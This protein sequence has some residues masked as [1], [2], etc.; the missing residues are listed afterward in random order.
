[1][2]TTITKVIGRLKTA[3][4]GF[5]PGQNSVSQT[6]R[7]AV[8]ALA[9]VA[10]GVVT[11]G[12][13]AAPAYT[14]TEGGNAVTS[15]ATLNYAKSTLTVTSPLVKT[16]TIDNTG[17][18]PLSLTASDSG[19][20]ATEFVTAQSTTSIPASSTGTVT[21]TFTPTAV[22]AER[23]TTLTLRTNA[24]AATFT[25]VLKA[26][27]IQPQP[28][29]FST[30]VFNAKQT[31]SKVTVT[32]TRDKITAAQDVDFST[33]DGP[34]SVDGIFTSSVAGTDYTTKTATVHF[35]V[36][37]KSKTVEI[38]LTVLTGSVPNR[39]FTVTIAPQAGAAD[40]TSTPTPTNTATVRVLAT[41]TVKPTLTVD[42]PTDKA[43]VNTDDLDD[44]Q[45]T[46]SGS[47]SDEKG[48]AS[49]K[50]SINGGTA[51]AVDVEEGDFSHKVSPSLGS[52]KV[53]VTALDYKGNSTVVTRTFTITGGN[54]LAVTRALSTALPAKGFNVVGTVALT[55]TSKVD[56][57]A[58]TP[59]AT[60]SPTSL[61]K[62]FPGKTVKLTAAAKTGYAF[63]HWTITPEEDAT[64]V[65]NVATIVMDADTTAVANFI[66]NPFGPQLDRGTVFAGNLNLDP[67]GT[68]SYQNAGFITGTL[69]AV[70]KFTG[71]FKIGGLSKSFI[72]NFRG[73]GT[74]SFGTSETLV[75]NGYEL[76]LTY[77]GAADRNTIDA[78]VTFGGKAIAGTL[79]RG[80]Y[81]KTQPAATLATTA[82]KPTYTMTF[83]P[84]GD[85]G[86]PDGNGICSITLSTLGVAN[87]TGTLADGSTFSGSFNMTSASELPYFVQLNPTGTTGTKGFL[88]GTLVFDT[89]D[90]DSDV[91]S[92]D[93]L[94]VR[95]ATS[96]A[97]DKASVYR[98]GWPTGT[99]LTAF[100]AFY[101]K[102]TTVASAMGLST[103]STSD[104]DGNA[105]LGFTHGS[106]SADIGQ[107]LFNIAGSVTTVFPSQTTVFSLTTGTSTSNTGFFS[108]EF[109]PNWSLLASAKP[110]FQGV[111]I[112]KG[113]SAG[114]YGFFIS[115]ADGDKDL[116]SGYVTLTKDTD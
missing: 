15:G 25:V 61:S 45:L 87:L 53:T 84:S 48:L 9:I 47:A 113:A 50:V 46:V 22:G 83:V 19:T 4:S 101:T 63:S 36:K 100:G 81:S 92:D 20:N 7:N 39:Q 65:G 77:G 104:T 34:A 74:G 73:D 112:Q 58:L 24:A 96:L 51:V 76:T 2:K 116:E 107:H 49:V 23:T 66:P 13:V 114:G 68:H 16:F 85:E 10:S 97:P 99:A 79:T 98:A 59:I 54:E 78:D 62:V 41:D 11:A 26:E 37:D 43:S 56:A 28:V 72:A 106:L 57:T 1:M 64:V 93:T 52:N 29:K 21:V 33:S 31:D 60:N 88:Q 90:D 94:W 14:V 103:V 67:A 80:W 71:V 105:T 89:T 55:T 5:I 12:A 42:A 69:D 27:V 95:P 38:P 86:T 82:T 70:G 110:K 115:N 35:N 8:A 91:T 17:D 32:I 102:A 30:S 108:G 40:G 18:A 109:T 6:L 44:G 3:H 111:V 75:F